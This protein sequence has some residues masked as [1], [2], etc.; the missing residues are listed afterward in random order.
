MPRFITTFLFIS[1]TCTACTIIISTP[2]PS[3]PPPTATPT[4]IPPPAQGP[5]VIGDNVEIGD[6]EYLGPEA[7]ESLPPL[8]ASVREV[9]TDEEDFYKGLYE[10]RLVWIE[11]GLELLWITYPC[12]TQPVVV[13]H[14]DAT[15]EFWPGEIVGPDC[16]A[17]GVIHKLTVQWQTSIPFEDWKFILHPPPLPEA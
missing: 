6:W 7:V 1:L 14:S 16:E 15:I 13:V 2:T 10:A 11:D 8:S 12:S 9:G 17:M 5:A 3:P 4:A